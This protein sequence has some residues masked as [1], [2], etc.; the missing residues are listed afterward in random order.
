MFEAKLDSPVLLKK[1][2]DAIKELVSDA[3]FECNDEGLKLQ[4][5]D[6]SHVALVA[7]NLKEEAFMKYRCDR[8]MPLGIHFASFSKVVRCAKDDDTIS[9]RAQ[10]DT[11]IL[12]LTYEAKNSDRID[13]YEMKLMDIDADALGI[14]DT[15]YDA[16]VRLSSSEFQRI[17]RDLM[18]IGE[19]VRVEVTKEGVRFVAEGEAATG[20]VLLKQ[21]G[22]GKI[23]KVPAGDKKVKTEDGADD[24]EEEEGGSRRKPKVKKERADDEDEEMEED[25]GGPIKGKKKRADD[26]EEEEENEEEEEEDSEGGSK[27]RKRSSKANG[28]SKKKSKKSKED[29][30]DQDEGGAVIHMNQHVSLTFS[31]KYLVTFSKSAALSK[32]V[33]LMMSNEVPLLVKYDFGNG[34]VSYYLAPK[35]GDDE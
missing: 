22:G 7:V 32:S 8:P 1:I 20:T 10:E 31:L 13:N 25:D 30:E 5:M 19:S 17:V 16:T 34:S 9:L 27:K 28:S 26:D 24:D 3:N 14:P 29:E 4:A 6:N 23:N 15:D 18:Q 2:L 35:I 11:D 21:S 12:Y 33:E